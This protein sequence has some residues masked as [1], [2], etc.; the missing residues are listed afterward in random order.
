MSFEKFVV[1]F[2]SRLVNISKLNMND[3]L[4]GNVRLR[5]TNLDS[6][7]RNIIIGL[8]GRTTHSRH[9]QKVREMP[10]G[11]RTANLVHKYRSSWMLLESTSSTK[12]YTSKPHITS[13]YNNKNM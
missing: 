3:D 5:Q 9:Y 12:G 6:H 11:R 8:S 7:E 1:G 4:R 2:H 13:A 10:I